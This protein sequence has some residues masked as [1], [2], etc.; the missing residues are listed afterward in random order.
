MKPLLPLPIPGD[1]PWERFDN[2]VGKLLS[3]PKEALLK[4][5][6]RHKRTRERKR[7]KA[8]MSA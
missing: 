2:A 1:T 3:V 5:E 7:T 6:V 4:E 8:R